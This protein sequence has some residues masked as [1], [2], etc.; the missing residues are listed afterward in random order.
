MK[1]H[2]IYDTSGE[3]IDRYTILTSPTEC[4]VVDDCGGRNFSQWGACVDGKHLG[5]R[6]QFEDL[7]K[8]T[9]DH[10]IERLAD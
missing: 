3:T 1:I 10:I 6:I 2:K 4:L 8:E 5:K 9:R 7:P